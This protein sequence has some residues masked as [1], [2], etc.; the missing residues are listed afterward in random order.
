VKTNESE[1]EGESPIESTPKFLTMFDQVED[2]FLNQF[3]D[4]YLEFYNQLEN[5]TKECDVL[6][7]EV[8]KRLLR[9]VFGFFK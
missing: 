1:Q 7:G 4:V 5:R 2:L 9:I 3:D 8:R 6:L